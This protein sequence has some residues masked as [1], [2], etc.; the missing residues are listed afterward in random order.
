MRVSKP[1]RR[2]VLKLSTAL[3]AGV[4]FPAP[5][6]AAVPAP[7]AVSQA[8]I[9][10]ARKERMVAFYTAMEIPLAESLGKAFEAVL[11]SGLNDRERS[12]CSGASAK[13]RTLA[14]MKPM[15]SAAQT[16]DIL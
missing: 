14:S 16:R 1:S 8:M 11:T 7:T 15:S 12:G 4:V 13:R 3:A 10:A 2:D 5:L 9:E 6:K